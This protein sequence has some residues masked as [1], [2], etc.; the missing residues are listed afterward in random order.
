MR[1]HLEDCNFRNGFEI[2]NEFCVFLYFLAFLR[3]KKFVIL[4]FCENFEGIHAANS[5]QHND[6]LKIWPKIQLCFL[7]RFWVLHH[8]KKI[9]AP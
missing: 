5:S 4:I 6:I 9:I 2:S 3:E 1:K 8:E 7:M